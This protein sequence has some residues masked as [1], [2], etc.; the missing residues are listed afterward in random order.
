M[1]LRICVVKLNENRA[2]IP[3]AIRKESQ[4]ISSLNNRVVVSSVGDKA[5]IIVCLVLH[6]VGWNCTE[7]SET[8]VPEVSMSELSAVG[9]HSGR[10]SIEFS[11]RQVPVT[12]L[13]DQVVQILLRLYLGSPPRIV[14]P[15]V[16]G[17]NHFDLE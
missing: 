6:K 1:P 16:V 5:W 17:L 12:F 2:T 10:V 14:A 9:I 11:T 8:M 7:I 15:R 4:R 3:I 13:D